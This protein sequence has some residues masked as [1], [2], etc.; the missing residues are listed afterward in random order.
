MLNAAIPVGV[1]TA[2]CLSVAEQTHA[3]I[4]LIR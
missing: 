3:L 4:V 1:V 2:T